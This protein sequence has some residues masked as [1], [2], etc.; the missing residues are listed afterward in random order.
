MDWLKEN[1]VK[2]VTAYGWK[3]ALIVLAVLFVMA[4]TALGFVAYFDIDLGALLP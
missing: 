2:F 3:P 4:L 1:I